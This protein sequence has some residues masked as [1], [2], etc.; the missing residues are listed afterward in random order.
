VTR[1]RYRAISLADFEPYAEFLADPECT[2]FLLVPG[3]ELVGW[4]GYVRRERGPEH[5]T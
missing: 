3:D 2:R 4:T 1:L 5:V